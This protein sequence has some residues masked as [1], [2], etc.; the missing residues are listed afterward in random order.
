MTEIWAKH[1]GPSGQPGIDYWHYFAQRLVDLAAIPQDSLILDIGTCDGN[2][3]FKAMDEASP[4]SLGV[5][6][7]IDDYG[8]VDG[9]AEASKRGIIKAGFAQ[10]DAA[11]LGFPSET[12]DCVLAN[13]V[14]WDDY[15]DFNLMEYIQPDTRTPEIMRIL[16]PGGQ[17]GIGYWVKQD[18]IDWMIGAFNRHLPEPGDQ[19][20]DSLSAYGK[21]NPEGYK[22]ILGDSGFQNIHSHVET[23]PFVL[24]GAESWWEQMKHATSDHFRLVTDPQI[25]EPFKVKVLSDLQE[26]RPDG[27]ILFHKTVAFTFGTKPR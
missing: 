22:I 10:M 3:L 12:F 4:L 13:F 19:T 17:L 14:G 6:I 24:P 11:H 16:K 8:F 25:I 21:E 5:G 1:I 15:F 7:D 23:T 18:D 27:E 26:S 20:W 2:V 9:I